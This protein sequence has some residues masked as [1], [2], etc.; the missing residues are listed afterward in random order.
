MVHRSFA[1]PID[2]RVASVERPLAGTLLE[3]CLA[4]SFRRQPGAADL[5]YT[6]EFSFDLVHWTQDGVWLSTTPNP[7]GTV[8]ETWRGPSGG[9]GQSQYARLRVTLKASTP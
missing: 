4:L 9:A 5:D 8:T 7:D 2:P 3:G 6:V 1:G